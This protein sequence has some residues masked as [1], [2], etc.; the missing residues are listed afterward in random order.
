MKT[1][2]LNSPNYDILFY[3]YVGSIID[4]LNLKYYTL[5]VLVSIPGKNGMPPALACFF[6]LGEEHRKSDN[7][8]DFGYL[9]NKD[10]RQSKNL[11]IPGVCFPEDNFIVVITGLKN[12]TWNKIISIYASTRVTQR[13]FGD[14][15][16]LFSILK[17]R[18]EKNI[19]SE[20]GEKEKFLRKVEEII[21]RE[22]RFSNEMD[23]D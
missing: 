20:E 18:I 4:I 14:E 16:N 7:L 5:K 13:L 12:N 11:D 19:F 23:Y 9:L 17:D 22:K 15:S 10:E 1:L 3:R 2:T 6:L 8:L 21:E